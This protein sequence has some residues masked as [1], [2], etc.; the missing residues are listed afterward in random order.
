MF[1]I[2]KDGLKTLMFFQAGEAR[3]KRN[4]V[5]VVTIFYRARTGLQNAYAVQG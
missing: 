5:F 3:F 4:R 1:N 2:A